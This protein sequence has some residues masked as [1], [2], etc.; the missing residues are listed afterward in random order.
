MNKYFE[1][2]WQALSATDTP[3]I[4]TDVANALPRTLPVIWLLGK[5]GAGKSSLVRC[6]TNV[7]EA[8][9]GNGFSPCTRTTRAFD[10]PADHPLMRFLDTR[11]LGEASYDPSED[12]QVC[13][14][15]SHVVIAVA[16]VDDPVQGEVAD[17]LAAIRQQAPQS[18]IIV[19][20]NG[21][22]LIPD[23][24]QRFRA[25]SQ[26]QQQFEAATGSTL[27]SVETALPT[28][29]LGL[30]APG[31]RKLISLLDEIM[32]EVVLLL[33]QE[34]LRDAERHSYANVRSRI[35]WYATAAG[36]TD[37][38]PVVGALAVPSIQAAMLRMLGSSYDVEWTRVRI[39]EF[40]MALGM[41]IAGRFG[42]SYFAR[43]LGKLVPGYGQTIGAA[44]AGTISF[45]TTF[46]LGR[47]AAYYLHTVQHGKAVSRNN[48]RALYK[49]ALRHARYDKN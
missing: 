12:L 22:D 24:D 43:Q 41:G 11:G 35:F 13:R 49:D 8:E 1:R 10:F 3:D 29:A 20:H 31:V 27:P 44:T 4:A 40:A 38:A 32:P 16:R 6:L 28:S 2:I 19:V 18:R 23:P 36:T 39:S 48:L 34:D 7:D 15:R 17:A 37:V 25:S 30:D 21:A 26:T 42:G 46:A 33:M 9:L 14:D 47:A 45:A 5:T